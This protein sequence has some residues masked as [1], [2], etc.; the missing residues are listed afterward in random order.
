MENF[1]KKKLIDIGIKG[2][3][4]FFSLVVFLFVFLGEKDDSDVFVCNFYNGYEGNF[5]FT[6]LFSYVEILAL[7]YIKDKNIK[8]KATHISSII[9]SVVVAF[10][11]YLNT[12]VWD[13]E[14]YLK[15]TAFIWLFFNIETILFILTYKEE[16]LRKIFSNKKRTDK[17]SRNIKNDINHEK[18]ADKTN[19]NEQKH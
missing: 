15:S 17:F 12:Y 11:L 5:I 8:N 18:T 1:D 4:L 6:F 10:I 2:F 9:Y 16:H 7:F 19:V 3:I 13:D 14:C